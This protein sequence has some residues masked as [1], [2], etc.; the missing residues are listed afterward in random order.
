MGRG[1]PR[2]RRRL[3]AT[4]A[5][6]RSMRTLPELVDSFADLSV[7]VVGEAMLDSYVEGTARGLSPEAPVP[8]VDLARRTDA[9]GGAANAAAN[10]ARLGADVRFFS[11]VGAD[12]EADLLRGA[13]SASG[14]ATDGLLASRDRRTLAK[15]RILSSGQML[16]RVDQ[17]S[18]EP[19]GEAVERELVERLFAAA[20]AA[21]AVLVSDYAYGVLTPPVLE[22]LAELERRDEHVV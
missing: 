4:A 2:C 18:I 19:A 5:G 6:G 12:P 22:A 8:I 7:V 14:V 10:A 1:L 17:G 20:E 11:V 15:Q 13:L 3:V 21:D 9:P 16:V